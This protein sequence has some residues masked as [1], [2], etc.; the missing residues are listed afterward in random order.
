M[1]IKTCQNRF[2]LRVHFR[3]PTP[4]GFTAILNACGQIL[5]CLKSYTPWKK[6]LEVDGTTCQEETVILSVF[7]HRLP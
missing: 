5:S 6:K 1:W 2:V 4:S 3:H 7:C